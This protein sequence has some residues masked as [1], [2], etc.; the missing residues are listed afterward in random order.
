MKAFFDSEESVNKFIEEND[1]DECSCIYPAFCSW[2]LAH[3]PYL[4]SFDK[5]SAKNYHVT[6]CKMERFE[7]ENHGLFPV[8]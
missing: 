7:S 8:E 4:D 3:L 5:I 1:Y 2:V 6:E